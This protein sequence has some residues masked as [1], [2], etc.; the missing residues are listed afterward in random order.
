[1]R[2]A[3][4][5]ATNQ[6]LGMLGRWWRKVVNEAGRKVDATRPDL[7]SQLRHFAAEV[8]TL[9]T[10]SNLPHDAPVEQFAQLA[11]HTEI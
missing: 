7:K 10:D 4:C 2:Y 5:V 9:A 11:T 8:K 3:I 1:M 6:L